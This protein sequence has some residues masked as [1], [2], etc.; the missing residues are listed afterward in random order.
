MKLGTLITYRTLVPRRLITLA[1]ALL[2]VALSCGSPEHNPPAHSTGSLQGSSDLS[3]LIDEHGYYLTITPAN[4]PETYLWEV[5]H[6]DGTGTSDTT[7][8]DHHC[9]SAFQLSDGTDLTITSEQLSSMA[10]QLSESGHLT[11]IG[12]DDWQH[13][14]E[15]QQANRDLSNKAIIESVS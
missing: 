1:P 12:L 8:S 13:Y 11:W 4:T 7:Y 6:H 15:I 9:T 5:C 10:A 2:F 14:K 3:G